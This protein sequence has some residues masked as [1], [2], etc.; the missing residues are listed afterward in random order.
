MGSPVLEPVI[1]AV[2]LI[3]GKPRLVQ[4]VTR[5]HLIGLP[6][7]R[8]RK[9][10]LGPR[11]REAEM[12][13]VLRIIFLRIAQPAD[14]P[15]DAVK[16]GVGVV[17]R[18]LVLRPVIG[19]SPRPVD[20]VDIVDRLQ[21]GLSKGALSKM[22]I[23][24]VK[25]SGKIDIIGAA[26]AHRADPVQIVII[27]Q[28]RQIAVHRGL[29]RRLVHHSRPVDAV[30]GEGLLI[31][32]HHNGQGPAAALGYRDQL[33]GQIAV[34]HAVLLRPHL[35]LL[36]SRSLRCLRLSLRLFPD[37]LQHD[38]FRGGKRFLRQDPFRFRGQGRDRTGAAGQPASP[39]P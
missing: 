5:A 15:L 3:V 22:S 11:G 19:R 9:R 12:P 7:V 13:L 30:L 18:P 23:D 36:V 17:G 20:A 28:D 21:I 25:L 2:V 24:R 26:A 37:G 33:S 31:I 10:H 27:L 14:H 39:Q 6:G 1:Q 16:A 4:P 32:A 38:F 8:S 34:D 29:H 35:D